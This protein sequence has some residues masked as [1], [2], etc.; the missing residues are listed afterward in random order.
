MNIDS[1]ENYIFN[2]AAYTS[3]HDSNTLRGWFETE[4][5][6]GQIERLGECIG[7][8]TAGEQMHWKVIK[9]AMNS[10]ARLVIVAMQDVLGLGSKARMNVP[11]TVAKSNWTW[12]LGRGR[13]DHAVVSRLKRMTRGSGRC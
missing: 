11:G 9:F 1:P 5:G 6:A 2:C 4:A 13:V 3:T 10:K 12:R 7:R 8:K